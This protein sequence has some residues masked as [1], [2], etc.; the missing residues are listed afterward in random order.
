MVIE[1]MA[2]TCEGFHNG[3]QKEQSEKFHEEIID[4]YNYNQLKIHISISITIIENCVS[5]KVVSL[6]TNRRLGFW[7]VLYELLL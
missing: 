7:S 2:G 5:V 1:N 6:E 4:R 3:K